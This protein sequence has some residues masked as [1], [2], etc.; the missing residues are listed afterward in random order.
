MSVVRELV[1]RWIVDAD[2][3][4]VEK[5]D[6]ALTKAIQKAD[7]MLPSLTKVADKMQ[8]V[9]RDLTTRVSAPLL[10]VGGAGVYAFAQFDQAMTKSLAIMGDV[11]DQM[12]GRMAASA[13]ATAKELGLGADKVAEG[14]YFLAAAGLDAT[15]SI[16]V[17]PLVSK[18]AKAGAFD[19]ALATD[20]LTDAQSALGLTVRDDVVKNMEN[21]TRVSDVL[22]KANTVANSSVQQ[23]S[24]ALTSRAGPALRLVKKDIEEGVA[25]LAVMADQGVKGAE[26]GTRLDIV[27]RDLQTRGIKSADEMKKLGIR[28][29]D[30]SGSMRNMADILQDLEGVFGGLSDEQARTT[31]MTLGF[32][33]RSVAAMLSLMGMSDQVRRYEAAL[34]DAGGMTEVVARKQMRALT[35]QLNVQK[36]RIVDVGISIGVI[37]APFVLKMARALASAAESFAK[38]SPFQQKFIIALA[39]MVALAGPALFLT[40]T[41]MKMAMVIPV[42]KGVAAAMGTTGWAAAAMAAKIMII[43]LVVLSLLA[44][45]ALLAEDLAVFSRGGKSVIGI[46]VEWFGQLGEIIS[47]AFEELRAEFPLLDSIVRIFEAVMPWLQRS[48]ALTPEEVEQRRETG[49]GVA[50]PVAPGMPAVAAPGL[51]P[52]IDPREFVMPGGVT[53]STTI[54]D[55]STNVFQI[56]VPEGTTQQQA[57]ELLH[58]VQ[59][60][61]DEERR[62]ATSKRV[63]R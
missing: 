60:R 5:F 40:G 53:Q 24:E 11:S 30:S 47:A 44:A 39:A 22:V 63:I 43:P 2:I 7:K 16:G 58:V 25:V 49:F 13:R 6:V 35:E 10:A 31:L 34:R 17:L 1:S 29:F 21:M 3:S 48:S 42:L 32:Q 54:E 20:L 18:F 37:L 61:L 15:Q 52:G 33:D 50:V 55:N 28:V 26:A 56:Q 4:T 8:N 57:D 38:L 19:L 27:L 46:A 59:E 51:A 62:S 41:L 45:L 36:Q 14:Y 23:F 12:R 9:G